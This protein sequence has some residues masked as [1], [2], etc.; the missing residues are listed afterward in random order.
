M[1][2]LTR[3]FPV[4]TKDSSKLFD[5]SIKSGKNIYLIETKLLRRY[6]PKFYILRLIEQGKF[7]KKANNDSIT[8]LVV[9]NKKYLINHIA[10]LQ[11]VWD[12]IFDEND[13]KNFRNKLAHTD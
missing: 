8:I 12:Y 4:T 6:P 10:Q 1:G 9:N 11:N 13:L 7:A 5:F 3:E 2:E